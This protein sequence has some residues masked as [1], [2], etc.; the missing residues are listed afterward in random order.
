MSAT[1]AN[2]RTLE[3]EDFLSQK[4]IDTDRLAAF[5]QR[6]ATEKPQSNRLFGNFT[7]D[8]DFEVPLI[9]NPSKDSA[10]DPNPPET[11]SN[12]NDPPPQ[13]NN[14]SP[15]PTSEKATTS[16]HIAPVQK[17]P[18]PPP[19]SPPPIIS[20]THRR[21][22]RRSGNVPGSD[23]LRRHAIR[24]RSQSC[25]RQLLKEFEESCKSPTSFV[26]GTC[27]T[28]HSSQ[29]LAS[30]PTSQPIEENAAP[31]PA[32][33]GVTFNKSQP[34]QPKTVEAQPEA[35]KSRGSLRVR[36]DLAAEIAELCE[37]RLNSFKESIL[38]LDSIGRPPKS[39]P[40][41][42]TS[43]SVTSRQRTYTIEKGPVP[44]QLLLSPSHRSELPL[45]QLSVNLKRIDSQTRV[46]RTP[47]RSSFHAGVESEP[48]AEIVGSQN[49]V[50]DT[51]PRSSFNAGVQSQP[52]PEFVVPE[53][54]PNNTIPQ[55]REDLAAVMTEDESDDDDSTKALNLAPKGGNTT[56]RTHLKEKNAMLA[57]TKENSVQLLDLHR[58]VKKSKKIEPVGGKPRMTSVP[59]NKP[60]SVP[61]NGEQFAEELARMSNYEI[62][63]LRKRNSMGKVYPVNGHSNQNTEQQKILEKNIEWELLRR[64]LRNDA[65]ALPGSSSSDSADNEESLPA[66]RVMTRN[67]KQIKAKR[68]TSRR[69]DK[70][71]SGELINYMNLTK[72]RESR[73]KSSISTSKRTLYTK[74]DSQC[75]DSDTSAS[76]KKQQRL[77]Q[78]VGN[79]SIVPPPPGY[80]RHSQSIV[81]QRSVRSSLIEN[82]V[83]P[84]PRDFED[85][86]RRTIFSQQNTL[87]IASPPPEYVDTTSHNISVG[88]KRTKRVTNSLLQEFEK[89]SG[90]R[91][92]C[93]ETAE[94]NVTEIMEG[95]PPPPEYIPPPSEYNE[96][97]ADT[98]RP[99]RDRSK[100]ANKSNANNMSN[101]KSNRTK[102][103]TSNS[104][105]SVDHDME[106]PVSSNSNTHVSSSVVRD[107]CLNEQSDNMEALRMCTPTPPNV[108]ETSSAHSTNRE[109]PQPSIELD[110]GPSTSNAAR[111]ALEKSTVA[112]KKNAENAA[113]NDDVFKKP[114]APAPKAKSRQKCK[115]EVKRL[116]SELHVTL[117]PV[118][119]DTSGIR[120]SARGHVPL[121]NNWVHSN[122]DL[123]ALGFMKKAYAVYDNEL[124]PKKN[125]PNK[126]TAVDKKPSKAHPV[127]SSTPRDSG[128]SLP[129]FFNSLGL[130]ELELTEEGTEINKI[131]EE[132][133]PAKAKK[134]GRKKKEPTKDIPQT[135]E[136]HK[137]PEEVNTCVSDVDIPSESAK[138]KEPVT[139]DVTASSTQTS[140]S[141]NMDEQMEAS[142]KWTNWLRGA[143]DYEPGSSNAF[144][145]TANRASDLAFTDIDGIDYAFYDT[146]EKAT[147]GYMR[148]KPYQTRNKK[149]AKMCDMKLI[150]QVGEFAIQIVSKEFGEKH[151]ILR[152]GDMIEVD[153]GSLYSIQNTL[154]DISVLLV[155]RCPLTSS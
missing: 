84:A 128:K 100:S 30:Q 124:K 23:K 53:T 153:G 46:A 105:I 7:F 73:R 146:K 119:H 4:D 131:P 109:R 130:E 74:G 113:S 137:D 3:L 127:C 58:S 35:E 67:R 5:L 143:S 117:P 8:V 116:A 95:I 115:N 47:S 98:E 71:M 114:L 88:S 77:S 43:P 86:S 149:R 112:S 28:P 9:R 12:E 61:I 37:E 48:Q 125:R 69:R 106:E 27:S 82:D 64:N 40:T 129:D 97:N 57:K 99:T 139:R 103:K 136:T 19:T 154:N 1:E 107:D 83:Y 80:L 70:P 2:E 144:G 126:K 94:A 50:P 55:I 22:V 108:Q 133:P 93:E 102:M 25:G 148:F 62:L 122:I 135:V 101:T 59:L 151:N 38:Q 91:D 36:T 56:R 39:R 123:K 32:E 51:P 21:S 26:P 42:P 15:S 120:R 54:Q 66:R 41:T 81:E 134:R 14:A 104:R 76:P 52:E 79:I 31:P 34:D 45:K 147:I 142:M 18:T 20:P 10:A 110:D 138:E 145:D 111:Q 6:K 89:D 11:A 24:R 87:R 65:G 141:I 155:I 90:H 85:S 49:S 78:T 33:N 92:V 121:Q 96:T 60:P 75:E 118:E 68:S 72:A 16:N 140:A 63:D 152:V 13:A 150:V 132:K 17:V 29:L 44:G